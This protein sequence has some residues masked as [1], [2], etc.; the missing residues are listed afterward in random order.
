MC[1]LA[2]AALILG[3]CLG[4][5]T[6]AVIAAGRLTAARQWGYLNGWCDGRTGRMPF[7]EGDDG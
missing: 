5:A 4:G 7:V 1:W 2:A 6:V 3:A